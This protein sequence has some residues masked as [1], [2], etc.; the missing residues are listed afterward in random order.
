MCPDQMWDPLRLQL[1]GSGGPFPGIKRGRGVTLTTHPHLLQRSRMC[2]S[3]SSSPP[4]RLHGG[5]GTAL[6]LPN[7]AL[8]NIRINKKYFWEELVSTF[9]EIFIYNITTRTKTQD[10]S[11]WK[12]WTDSEQSTLQLRALLN[13]VTNLR[14]SQKTRNFL[15]NWATTHF[16]KRILLY[17]VSLTFWF[18]ESSF[19]PITALKCVKHITQDFPTYNVIRFIHLQGFVFN[20]PL[21]C[22]KSLIPHSPRV[23]VNTHWDTTKG[24][25][26]G[27]TLGTGMSG[28][29]LVVYLT[30]LKSGISCCDITL[31][32]SLHALTTS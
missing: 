12:G 26:I 13:M 10:L 6:P 17:G 2:M 4:C 16:T 22:S 1:M 23:S 8:E 32:L 21:L 29:G 9:Y 3:Y 14:V 20:T 7:R 15:T 5:S 18:A 25:K 24:S 19:S 31:R 11:E 28:E 27:N 30:T